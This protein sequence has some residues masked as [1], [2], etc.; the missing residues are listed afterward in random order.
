MDIKKAN[1]YI[2]YE[3][4]SKLYAW[5][6]VYEKLIEFFS[7]ILPIERVELA[8]TIWKTPIPM[9]LSLFYREHILKH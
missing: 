7:N 3:R 5:G 2:G 9:S 4:I 6:G 1:A 8:D